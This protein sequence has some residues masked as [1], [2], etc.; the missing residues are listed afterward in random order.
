M[1]TQQRRIGKMVLLV[2]LFCALFLH[3]A[4]AEDLEGSFPYQTSGVSGTQENT[5]LGYVFRD[6]FFA[7]SSYRMN[8]ELARMSLR[9]AVAGF[10]VGEKSDATNLL[11][12]FDLLNIHYDE[13][14]VH[15][16]FPGPDTIGY[17]YGVREIGENESLIVAVVRGGN[18]QTE[19]AGNFTLGTTEDHEGFRTCADLVVNDLTEYIRQMPEGRKVSVLLTG[20][21]RGA[22]VSNLAAASLDKLASE[23]QFG[24]VSPENIYA[25][26]FACPRNTLRLQEASEALYANIVSFVHPAVPVPKVAPGEWGYGRFG[27]TYLLSTSITDDGYATYYETFLPIYLRY[28]FAG[29]FQIHTDN[30]ISMDRKIAT[31][32]STLISPAF[33]V[34][35]AQKTLRSAFMGAESGLSVV[36]N[37]LGAPAEV[38][39]GDLIN[40]FVAHA[41]ELYLAALDAIGDGSRLQTCRSDYGFLICEADAFVYI[42]DSEGKQVVF[43][44][45]ENCEFAQEQHVCGAVYD[46]GKLLFDFP[47]TERYYV[48][49]PSTEKQK[50][51]LQC[52]LFDILASRD[53]K[54]SDFNKVS[55]QE[56]ECAV[57][58]LDP[59]NPVLYSGL[60]YAAEGVVEAL[61]NG[62]AI[63]AKQVKASK[64]V[65][66]GENTSDD[67]GEAEITPT[68]A[69]EPTVT[70]APAETTKSE[71]QPRKWIV[72]AVCAAAGIL[73]VGVLAFAVFRKRKKGGEGNDTVR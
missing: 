56:G 72:P 25:Y 41:P 57:L 34:L 28:S 3:T 40:P 70:G 5:E 44:D 37:F 23:S 45:G 65:V 18:Y 12:L 6:S 60:P 16:T 13:N 61:V 9:L 36:S 1:R 50:I 20:Y 43:A 24:N 35:T 33:Y 66:A 64:V 73:V 19:W 27:T 59:E 11:A 29:D 46:S 15:Y 52:G 71:S 39:E 58:V 62:E 30:I 7:E 69:P 51:T 10:G 2:F 14:T 67:P 8:P 63:D 68:P 26:C 31:L 55:L 42:F 32:A 38:G 21:S 22:A 17:A 4:Y 53:A 49:I 54:R 48:V 47:S